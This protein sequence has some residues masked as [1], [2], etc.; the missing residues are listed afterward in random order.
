MKIYL[1]ATMSQNKI[2][3]DYCRQN[4]ARINMLE[5]FYYIRPWQIELLS[6]LKSFMLDSGAFTFMNGQTVV[7]W[8]E[9]VKEYGNFVKR[10][11]IK[12]FIE[13]DI[14]KVVGWNQ[15]L[16]LKKMLED[17]SGRSPI[18]VFHRHHGKDYFLE[19]VSKNKYI[20]IGGIA[21][22]VIKPSEHRYFSWFINEAHKAGAKIHG[23]GFTHLKGLEMYP[24]DTVDSSSWL[25]SGRYGYLY[26]YKDGSLISRKARQNER[27]KREGELYTFKAWIK[28]A[29]YMEACR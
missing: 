16:D 6:F 28:Y 17:I 5:S 8:K 9:Y 15:Y 26:Q 13:L 4:A 12:N 18:P 14:D 23:L 24:F 21:A 25:S 11:N 20:A 7:N 19:L 1:A 22:R 2:I 10:Y 27:L 29:E 3:G